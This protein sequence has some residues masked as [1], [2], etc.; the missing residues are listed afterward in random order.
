MI[1]KNSE[2]LNKRLSIAI[3]LNSLFTVIEFTIGFFTGSLAL[4][5][6]AAHNLTDVLSLIISF[7][8]HKLSKKKPD[9]K[10]TFGYGRVAILGGLI[11]ALILL[12]LSIYIFIEAYNR[13]LKPEKID[14]L[15]VLFVGFCGIIINGSLASLFIKYKNDI[16][17]RSAL[18]NMLS[19]ALASLGA[20]IAGLVILLTNKTFIDPLISI[21]IGILLIFTAYNILSDIVHIL[22]EGIPSN[23]DIK[24][25]E[26]DIRTISN[27][28][29]VNDL[30]VWSIS[31]EYHALSCHIAVDQ[32]DIVNNL[33]TI[34]EIKKMLGNKFNIEHS[35]IEI[36]LEK[37]INSKCRIQEY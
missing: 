24:Q 12:I 30:H 11:N 35:T 9:A 26:T 29:Q 19:D 6:D 27:V 7:F 28:T 4:I 2:D 21:F 36:N 33:E 15:L 14:G 31:S 25:L 34:K 23:I 17:I 13:F 3:I 37:S 1:N 8:A 18:A 20:F 5:S 22:L 16:N 10:K 32:K